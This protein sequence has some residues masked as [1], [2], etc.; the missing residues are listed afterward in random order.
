[1]RAP[2]KLLGFGERTGIS[3]FNGVNIIF[4]VDAEEILAGDRVG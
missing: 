1:L 2:G 4:R 3:G